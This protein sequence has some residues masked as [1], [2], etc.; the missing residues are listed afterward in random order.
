MREIEIKQIEP[1]EM[2]SYFKSLTE[3]ELT[4]QDFLT[5]F[6]LKRW[7]VG[8][9]SRDF[10]IEEGEYLPT[11]GI[12]MKIWP[13]ELARFLILL[14]E[15]KDE[16]NSYLEFGTGK[17]GSFYMIDSYLRAINPNM[18][19]SVTIDT[20]ET[21]PW[22]FEEYKIQNPHIE[23]YGMRSQ[24]FE[25]YGE[26]DLCFID[27]NHRYDAVKWD[28]ENVKDHCKII[29][30]HDIAT[31][32]AKKPDQRCVRHLWAEIEAKNKMDIITDDPR[33]SFM[34]GIGVIWND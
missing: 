8:F 29:A 15:R 9:R 13:D 11:K 20:R 33:I 12:K 17:G 4:S 19:R 32:N 25:M 10:S 6:I 2:I 22:G 27:A 5:E 1:K 28:Y 18:G 23:Y 31:V 30:F 3:E 16:I 24:D 26:Y 7:G 21:P 14:Y 34:S